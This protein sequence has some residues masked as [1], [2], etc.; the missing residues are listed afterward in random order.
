MRIVRRGKLGGLDIDY[1]VFVKSIEDVQ[2]LHETLLSKGF[3]F[4]YQKGDIPFN[5]TVKSMYILH[6][7]D[8]HLKLYDYAIFF[9]DTVQ[10]PKKIKDFESDLDRAYKRAKHDSSFH[11]DLMMYMKL[12][13]WLTAFRKHIKA[14]GMLTEEHTER[15]N[16]VLSKIEKETGLQ[17]ETISGDSLRGLDTR[18]KHFFGV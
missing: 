12:H 6:Y 13:T 2:K 3:L 17:V 4:L 11:K 7:I 18:I 8:E 15:L 14:Y 1:S 16:E 10:E 9:P 5:P